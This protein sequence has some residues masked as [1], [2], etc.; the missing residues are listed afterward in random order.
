MK[1]KF[2]LK[3][4]LSLAVTVLMLVLL[5]FIIFIVGEIREPSPTFFLEITIIT[6]LVLIIRFNWYNYGEDKKLSEKEITDKQDSL[7]TYRDDEITNIYDF[8]K[9]LETLNDDNRKYYIKNKMKN[10]TR[11]NCK[12][13]DKLLEKYTKLSLKKVRDVKSSDIKTRG[14]TLYLVDSKNYANSKKITFQIA[15]SIISI[16][17]SIVLACIGA[18]EILLNWAN[19]FRYFGY[20]FIMCWTALSTLTYAMRTTGIETLDYL[21]RIQFIIDKY[22]NWKDGKYISVKGVEDG[23]KNS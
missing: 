2:S 6:I 10:R 18:K 15:S 21:K 12:N 16:V 7:D 20:V 14:D 23:D 3:K 17:L 1:S 19:V 11:A 5:F 13:Y 22:V 9:F 8:E 4:F